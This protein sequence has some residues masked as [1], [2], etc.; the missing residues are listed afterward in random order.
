MFSSRSDTSTCPCDGNQIKIIIT[1]IFHDGG[2]LRYGSREIYAEGSRGE[3]ARDR[4]RGEGT[5][6]KIKL[7]HENYFHP[8]MVFFVDLV[9]FVMFA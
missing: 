2:E 7:P 4:E 5:K 6:R 8:K 1:K 9:D 3:G